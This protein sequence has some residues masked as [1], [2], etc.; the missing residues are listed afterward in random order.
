MSSHIQGSSPEDIQ[1]YSQHIK[2]LQDWKLCIYS[3]KTYVWA[4]Y[5]CIYN[6][7]HVEELR[8]N[9]DPISQSLLL[10]VILRDYNATAYVNNIYEIKHTTFINKARKSK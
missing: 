4:T 10:Q 5:L 8:Q 1:D 6:N 3:L 9:S 7:S 2:F